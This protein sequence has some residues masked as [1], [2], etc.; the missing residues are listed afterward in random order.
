MKLD[1]EFFE[2]VFCYKCLTDEIFIASVIDYIQPY[3]FKNNDVRCI[4]DII[5]DFFKKRNKPPTITEL[6]TYLSDQKSKD[7]FKHL[8]PQFNTIDKDIDSDELFLNAET[9]IKEQAVLHTLNN[10][11]GD[12]EKKVKLNA[13]DVLGKF[14]KACNICLN[15]DI[16]LD[17]FSKIDLVISQIKQESTYI[18]TGWKWLDKKLNGGYQENGRALY[19][20]AG[21]TN[22]G[23]SIFLGNTACAI[24]KQGKTVLVITLEMAEI[25][26]AQRTLSSVSD[27][28]INKLK[29]TTNE[30]RDRINKFKGDNPNAR[31]IV[32]EFP[33]SSLTVNQ[34][35]AFIKKIESKGIKIDA[36]VLD[37]INLLTTTQGSNSYERIKH[38]AEQ[39]RALSYVYKCPIITAT[40]LGRAGVGEE[41]PDFDKVSESMALPATA[42]AMVSIW[43]SDIDRT[44]GIIQ[45]GMMKNRF[46]DRNGACKLLIDYSTLTIREDETLNNTNESIMTS[47]TLK[48][49][50]T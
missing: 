25:M 42:D 35:S 15:H 29:E 5:T 49:F 6:R 13:A 26:Y 50:S 44:Q 46:G 38:I 14:E 16:G 2:V 45:I 33:P 24:A 31:F 47:Q 21:I 28:P 3:Y 40:Q 23:K 34:L 11:V 36:I 32:K 8:A 7:A 20:F 18:S 37:Y 22:V 1:S 9:F 4:I 30:L 10:I 43:Q 39:L 41:N 12:I 48:L 17:L 27:I 19:V